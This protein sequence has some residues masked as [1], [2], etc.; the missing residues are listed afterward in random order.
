MAPLIL[1][2][3][4]SFRATGWALLRIGDPFRVEEVGVIATEKAHKK[5]KAFAGD[6]NHR[7]ASI[8]AG[9]LHALMQRDVALICAEA[10]AGSKSSKAA[11]MMGMA[12]GVVSAVSAVQNLPVLQARPTQVK[13]ANCGVKTASKEDVQAAVS[14]RF[15]EAAGLLASVKKKS[16]HEH[17]YDALSV[18]VACFDSTEVRTLVRA[19][20][21]GT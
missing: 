14:N 12:W 8:L 7:C 13:E 6:D 16:L 15:P 18:A 9:G 10:Q 20:T 2:L 4:P 1:A 11:Q 19:Y 5:D 17:V 21:K 3:D